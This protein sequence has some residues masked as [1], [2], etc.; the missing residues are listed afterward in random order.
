MKPA[1]NRNESQTIEQQLGSFGQTRYQFSN[2]LFSLKSKDQ[3]RDL[4]RVRNQS[5]KEL[6]KFKRLDKSYKERRHISNH[7]MVNE[8]L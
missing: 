1:L 3:Y 4:G 8:I 7:S 5:I 6:L 2:S